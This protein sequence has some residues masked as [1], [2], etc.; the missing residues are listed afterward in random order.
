MLVL[1]LEFNVLTCEINKGSGHRRVVG[2]LDAYDP[3][4]AKECADVGSGF[5]RWPGADLSHFWVIWDVTL[6]CAFVAQ[7]EDFMSGKK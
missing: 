6:V 3:Y 7:D 4:S 2:D 1:A 5:A